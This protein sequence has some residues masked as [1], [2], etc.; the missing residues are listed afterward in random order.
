MNAGEMF[1]NPCKSILQMVQMPKNVL[2]MK[3]E[4]DTWVTNLHNTHC[5]CFSLS[6]ICQLLSNQL[7]S[8]KFVLIVHIRPAFYVNANRKA[9][10]SLQTS[11]DHYKC[12]AKYKNGL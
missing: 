10:E 2:R 11:N 12:L 9:S 3:Q 1:Y 8:F 4:H 6:Y 7:I 5:G